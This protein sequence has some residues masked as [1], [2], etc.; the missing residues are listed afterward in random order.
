MSPAPNRNPRE[1]DLAIEQRQSMGA[2]IPG[3]DLLEDVLLARLRTADLCYW[4]EGIRLLGYMIWP[5]A[6][7][8]RAQWIDAH[9]TFQ[10]WGNEAIAGGNPPGFVTLLAVTKALRTPALKKLYDH[11]T[12]IQFREWRRTAEL[13]QSVIDIDKDKVA[14]AAQ[15][16]A[17]L[18]KAADLVAFRVQQSAKSKGETPPRMGR[19]SL[20]GT[21]QEYRDVAH[22]IAAAD[23]LA[24]EG[25]KR[26]RESDEG[27][28]NI[29]LYDAVLTA[30]DA[31][32]RAALAYQNFGLTYFPHSRSDPLLPSSLW[33]IPERMGIKPAQLP[34]ITLT[35]EDRDFLASK[36]RAQP[37]H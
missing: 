7:L 20:L 30:P 23:I 2:L 31:L 34:I 12:K 8:K 10:S 13:F 3:V 33:Q 9:S 37:V 32:L 22:F 21:W 18:G 25:N 29:D 4:P 11:L 15:G 26:L 35:D 36:R 17:S 5:N 14:N 6:E 27:Q 1:I 16:G 28:Y 24:R 19:T